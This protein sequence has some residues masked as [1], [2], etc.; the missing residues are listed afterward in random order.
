MTSPTH[1]IDAAQN[2]ATAFAFAGGAALGS[3]QAGMVRA[4]F[5]AGIHPDLITGGSSGALNGAI[6]ASMPDRR[7]AERLARLWIETPRSRY[8]ALRPLAILRG[9]RGRA[10]H[11]VSPDGLRALIERWVPVRRLE[12]TPVRLVVIAADA[13]SRGKVMLSEGN[14]VQAL[15]A[16]AALPGAFP[17]V[18]I[19]GRELVDGALVEDPPV[20]TA[21]EHGAGSVYVLPVGWPIIGPRRVEH[22][23]GFAYDA[24]DWLFSRL[25]VLE[26]ERCAASCDLYVLPSPATNGMMPF[27]NRSA[28]QLIEEAYRLASDWLERPCR[29]QDDPR[30]AVFGDLVGIPQARAEDRASRRRG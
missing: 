4:L 20:A 10:D 30:R 11:F 8:F 17:P 28:S 13:R 19:D 12:D 25:G 21:I 29:W 23:R 2:D 14:L 9:L 15:L 6:I 1:F 7:G 3:V 24:I 22:A 16:S 27:T 18:M 26:L 5:D